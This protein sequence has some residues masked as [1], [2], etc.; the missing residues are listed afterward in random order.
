MT[1]LTAVPAQLTPP[2]ARTAAFARAVRDAI[3]ELTPDEAVALITKLHAADTDALHAHIAGAERAASEAAGNERRH[4]DML[5]QVQ[6]GVSQT[7]FQQAAQTAE[8]ATLREIFAGIGKA[9]HNSR[10]GVLEAGKVAALLALEPLEPV[11]VP[12][13]A[14]FVPSEQYRGGQFRSEDGDDTFVFTFIGW[15]LVD[16]GPGALGS[17]EP[18]F[19]VSDRAM[20]RSAVEGERDV[21]LEGLLPNTDPVRS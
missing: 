2:D 21:T 15:A 11:H 19:L 13:V 12:S 18:M 17:L 5:M 20:P 14:A 9:V 6:H 16:H 7:T 4:W 10:N 3:T 8:I 1:L